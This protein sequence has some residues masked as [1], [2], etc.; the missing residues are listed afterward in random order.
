MYSDGDIRR[1]FGRNIGIDPFLNSRVQPSSYDVLLGNTFQQFRSEDLAMERLFDPLTE[2]PDMATV[3]VPEDGTITVWPGRFY[4]GAT[5]ERVWLGPNIAASLEGKSSLGRLGLSVHSTAGFID[6]GF[7]GHITLEISLVSG[8]RPLILTPGMR[9]GQ[10]TFHELLN[11]CKEPYG[12]ANR[13]SKYNNQGP[14]PQ[15]S[16]YNQNEEM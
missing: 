13:N 16:K 9:I 1:N 4:L 14:G 6:P 3:V 5:L 10:L 7:N 8:T 15:A 11:P 2:E 12:H